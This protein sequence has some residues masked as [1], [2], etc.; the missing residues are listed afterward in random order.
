M[1][2]TPFH[3]GPGAAFKAVGR[4]RFS[5]SVF[6]LSQVLLDVEPGL[7]LAFDWPVL[8]GPSHTWLA[9]L[10]IALLSVLP[11]KWLCEWALRQWNRRVGREAWRVATPISWTAA[12]S[13]SLLGGASH[14]LLDS[15]L[16]GD[17]RPWAP[18]A[19][20]NGLLGALSPGLI[21]GGCAL[22]GLL[23]GLALLWQHR[24]ALSR[25]T[26]DRENAR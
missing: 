17:M 3:L 23:G 25:G 21:Y 15:F 13:A 4:G 18:L 20:D 16:Y 22:L 9:A 5:F 1:P 26:R 11:G 2:F 19:E 12:L 8:H 6:A 7:G 24:R 10:V 14:I